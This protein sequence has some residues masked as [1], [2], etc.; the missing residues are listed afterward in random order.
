M[1]LLLLQSGFTADI[2]IDYIITYSFP[3]FIV[4]ASTIISGTVI[5]GGA[6]VDAITISGIIITSTVIDTSID[7]TTY[8]LID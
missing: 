7:L 8:I 5:V 4:G 1:L 2:S 6:G 3:S